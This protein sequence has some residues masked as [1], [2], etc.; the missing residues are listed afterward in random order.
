MIIVHY[1][2]LYYLLFDYSM[3]CKKSEL[4]NKNFTALPCLIIPASIRTLMKRN[5][6]VIKLDE[7]NIANSTQ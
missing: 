6:E 3:Y 2:L 1:M 4:G 5:S 7:Q